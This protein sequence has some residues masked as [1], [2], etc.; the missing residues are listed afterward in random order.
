MFSIFGHFSLR[1]FALKE[2]NSIRT[3]NSYPVALRAPGAP[4][5]AFW[6]V[7]LAVLESC[8]RLLLAKKEKAGSMSAKA[9]A[10]NPGH[11]PSLRVLV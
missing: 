9:K 1:S 5:S 11:L 2:G 10:F 7:G 4:R 3:L 8:F 6:N